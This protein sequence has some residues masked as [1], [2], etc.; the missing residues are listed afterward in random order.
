MAQDKE[1]VLEPASLRDGEGAC[2]EFIQTERRRWM[3]AVDR[4]LLGGAGRALA[5][6]RRLAQAAAAASVP[7]VALAHGGAPSRDILVFVMLR[8]GMD[9]LSLCVPHQ[10]PDYAWQRGNLAVPGPG[11]IVEVRHPS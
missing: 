11:Q 6:R 9:G 1:D 2:Q 5:G 10:D 3:A 7:R 8:G 4:R